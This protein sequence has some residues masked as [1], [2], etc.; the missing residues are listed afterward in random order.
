M[1]GTIRLT[2]Q[3]GPHKGRRFCFRGPTNCLVG[4]GP[5]CFMRFAGAE[6]DLA[7]SR[8]HCQLFVNPPEV[9]IQD[10]C[11]LNGTYINGHAIRTTD[12][13]TPIGNAQS[14]DIITVGGTSFVVDVVECPDTSEMD[15]DSAW[16]EGEVT[17]VDCPI[18][19][20]DGSM[21]F[22]G[23]CVGALGTSRVS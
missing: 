6:R 8:R 20:Q 7:I 2:V 3:T 23:G 13:D 17:K 22:I 19:C 10:L 4:R 15:H 16:K 5:D 21:P 14:G 1:A 9:R 12:Q 18:R 11:S